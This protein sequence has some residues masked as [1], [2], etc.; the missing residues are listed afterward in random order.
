M[1]E[2]ELIPEKNM[3]KI[4]ISSNVLL[5]FMPVFL[6]GFPSCGKFQLTIAGGGGGGGG[7]GAA[8]IDPGRGGGGGGGGGGSLYGGG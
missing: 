6:I 7:G 2:E 5:F 8:I 4:E 3:H 1:E